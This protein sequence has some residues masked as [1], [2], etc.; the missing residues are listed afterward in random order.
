MVVLKGK[1]VADSICDNIKNSIEELIQ[2]GI[3]PGLAIVRVGKKPDDIYYESSAIKR[4]E[5]VGIRVAS[6][7]LNENISESALITKINE[8]NYDDG[9]HGILLLM[10]LP[11]H[12]NAENVKHAIA[13]EKD[14]DGLTDENM[15]RLYAGDKDGFAPCTPSAVMELLEYY[16]IDVTGKNVVIVGRSLVVGKPL[17][18]LMLAKNATVTVCHSKTEDIKKVCRQAD[19]L[20]AAA[21]RAKMINAEYISENALVIDVG[22]NQDENGNM[23]GDADYESVCTKAS[24]VTPVPGGIGSITTSVLAKHTV[25]AALK[26]ID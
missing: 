1:P 21:G 18:M 8:L 25:E 15:C 11:K 24:A 17:L 12:I 5:S 23:C 6:V 13:P 3:E 22:I 10:P 7:V 2:K 26:L 14:I 19:I 4:M 9:I 20:V 16:N